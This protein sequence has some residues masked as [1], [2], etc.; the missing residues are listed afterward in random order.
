M[1][2]PNS[3]H[4][5]STRGLVL[6]A[7]VVLIWGTMWPVSK[8]LLEYAPPIWSIAFRT[9]LGALALFAISL[10]V[11]GLSLPRREDLPVVI[12]MSLL[13]MVGFT[14]LSTLGLQ[15]VPAG[16][17]AVLAYTSVLWAPLG[18][19]VFLGERLSPARVSGILL[20]ALG[21]GI[22]FNPFAFDWNDHAAALGNGAVLLAAMLWAASILHNRSHVWRSSPFQLSPWQVLLAAVVVSVIA[23]ALEGPPEMDVNPLSMTLLLFAGVLGVALAYWAVAVSSSELPASTTS[24]GL[25]A[26]PA[27]SVIVSAILLGERPSLP[28]IVAL[29][30]ILAGVIVGMLG[31][32]SGAGR[33]PPGR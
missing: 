29:V 3:K 14:V 1:H 31:T 26:T 7:L 19:V 13:H 22:I 27:V 20:G 33:S 25:L 10:L 9:W 17:T 23:F 18:A 30:M 4:A 21:L 11:T 32:V 6:L 16:Q 2:D 5:R 12:S 28:L 15:L 8:A 24:V